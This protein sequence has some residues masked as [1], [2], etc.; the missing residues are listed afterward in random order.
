MVRPTLTLPAALMISTGLA[1]LAQ[2]QA[3][4]E[5]TSIE[6]G[7]AGIARY[8]MTAETSGTRIRFA[9]PAAASS[10]VLASLIVR[11]PAGGVVDLQT[12]TPGSAA[13]ALRE[14][15][16]AAGIPTDTPALLEALKGQEVTLTT[17][18]GSTTGRVMG[19]RRFDAVEDTQRVDRLAALLLTQDG[20]AEVVLLPGTKVTFSQEAAQHLARAMD[21]SRIAAD[22]RQFD[23]TLAADTPRAVDLSYVTEAA[24]WKNSWRLLLDEGRLQGW[25]TF[26]NVSGADWQDVDLTLTTGAPVAYRRDLINPLMIARNEADGTH[27]VPID[28]QADSGVGLMA[29]ASARAAPAPKMEMEPVMVS[30]SESE[31]TQLQ[32]SGIL[33]YALPNPVDL[34]DGRT[35]NLM[36]LDLPIE[37]DIRG[38]YRPDEMEDSI[39]LAAAIHADQPLAPGLVSVQDKDGFVGDA[40]FDGM[41]AGQT[42]LLPFAAATGSTIL[43]DSTERYALTT[44]VHMQGTLTMEFQNTRT[45]TYSGAMPEMVDLFTVEHPKGFGD[46]DGATGTIEHGDWFYRITAPVTDGKGVISLTEKAVY[47]RQVRIGDGNFA[48]ILAEIASG[49][50]SLS[51][52]HRAAFDDARALKT[53]IDAA[54]REI[55]SLRGRY[56]GLTQEQKR[57]RE[58]LDS[59]KQEAL[60]DRYLTALDKTETEIAGNFDRINALEAQISGLEQDLLTVFA[61]F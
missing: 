2:A 59:V 61:G 20:V 3:L 37:P 28:V 25:A 27:P 48:S 45:T 15:E 16:F 24:A 36:Y 44:L 32:S 6:L 41:L 38:L 4:P 26:E 51:D 17:A 35:A 11:D 8:T 19:L 29:M 50:V 39:L 5:I 52:E 54:K 10:D 31:G 21:Q 55:E 34:Q 30:G 43:T 49:Q 46:I 56:D 22:V 1:G 60:R 23:L 14:T 53:R 18:L 9:V 58:N 42:R 40:R 57:L 13:A 33:R 47:Q 12:D 7:Q